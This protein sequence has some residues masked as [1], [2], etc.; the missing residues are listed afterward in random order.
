MGFT[1]NEHPYN[2]ITDKNIA[3]LYLYKPCLSKTFIP[4]PSGRGLG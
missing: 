1:R 4:S 2:R 3:Y